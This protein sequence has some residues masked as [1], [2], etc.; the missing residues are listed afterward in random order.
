MYTKLERM[1]TLG[2]WVA[3]QDSIGDWQI[4][5]ED[6]SII[7]AKVCWT[8]L[9]PHFQAPN[10]ANLICALH[11]M[12]VSINPDNPQA[13]AEGM[14]DAIKALRDI[15]ELAP[16]EKLRLP[17]AIQAV[18]IADQALAG[19]NRGLTNHKLRYNIRV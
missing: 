2:N 9:P 18:E 5:T 10:N 1:P 15:T 13:V 3:R 14:E 19:V 12:A 17:Y 11:N 16:R 6:G 7:I 4:E 8:E